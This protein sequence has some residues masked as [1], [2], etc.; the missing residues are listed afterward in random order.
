MLCV[1]PY[2]S[3]ALFCIRCTRLRIFRIAPFK[4]TCT[5]HVLFAVP[6][7]VGL[8]TIVSMLS[9]N[10]LAASKHARKH[11]IRHSMLQQHISSSISAAVASFA[12]QSEFKLTMTLQHQPYM[13]TN[14]QST[15]QPI[16][17]L[18]II[19][20]SQI[21]SSVTGLLH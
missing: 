8:C 17:G 19:L 6:T 10:A 13:E 11:H 15:K 12:D 21:N 7:K 4:L 18:T 1:D 20:E 16:I 5:A 14:S 9:I 3:T 2:G